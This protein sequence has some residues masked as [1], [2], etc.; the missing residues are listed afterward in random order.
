MRFPVLL[1]RPTDQSRRFCEAVR[2]RLG[3]DWPIVVSPLTRL[4]FLDPAVDLAGIA[5]LVFTSETAVAAFLRLSGRRDLRVWAVGPRTAEAA[6][7]AG[8]QTCTGPGN[9]AGLA[10][11]LR[12]GPP[13][14]KLLHV[15]GTE[16]AFPLAET[17]NSAGTDTV[18]VV[19]YD[20]PPV[21]LSDEAR[22]LLSGSGPVL[23]PLFS[24]RAAGLLRKAM[25]NGHAPL[26]VAAIS[27][28]V[29]SAA[30]GLAADALVVARTPDSPGML[31]ALSFL[32]DPAYRA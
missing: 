9:A 7:A 24:P 17:L 27:D 5:G 21:P 23:V 25:T 13:A 12:A 20:Q 16:S 2:Q 8:F 31:D 14:G 29:A 32:A 19:A 10:D 11:L 30:Q 15:R 4:V 6:A 26:R 22:T 18:Q 3:Q 28:A 1:T